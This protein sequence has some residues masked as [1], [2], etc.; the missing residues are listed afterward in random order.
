LL[1]LTCITAVKCIL[2]LLFE[3][4]SYVVQ[5]NIFGTFVDQVKQLLALS[6][7]RFADIRHETH[8]KGPFK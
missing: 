5:P 7:K 8:C 6:Y 1:T 3:S 4:S 2:P